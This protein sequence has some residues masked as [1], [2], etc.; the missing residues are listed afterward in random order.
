MLQAAAARVPRLARLPLAAAL[1]TL[2]LLGSRQLGL[3]GDPR[4]LQSPLVREAEPAP[5]SADRLKP[6]TFSDAR[7]TYSSL[8][9][10]GSDGGVSP[11]VNVIFT[12]AGY[13]RSG[14]LHACEQFNVR[15]PSALLSCFE[16]LL[17]AQ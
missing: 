12:R 6:F 9:F 8:H 16:S 7:G 4:I 11:Y 5:A 3:R 17:T 2:L 13:L 1:F 10:P 15:F 14:D